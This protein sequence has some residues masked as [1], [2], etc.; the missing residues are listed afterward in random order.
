[1]STA[2]RRP[3]R[4]RPELVTLGASAELSDATTALLGELGAALLVVPG[5]GRGARAHGGVDAARRAHARATSRPR[6]SSP[7]PPRRC[8]WASTTST[9]ACSSVA[10]P[11]PRT[12]PS[13][14]PPN[15]WPSSA[16]SRPASSRRADS[17]CPTRKRLA[18]SS[19]IALE[20]LPRLFHRADEAGL[21]VRDGAFWLESDLGARVDAAERGRPL[22]PPRPVLARPDS[23]P[24]ARARRASQRDAHR[25]RP[26][27]RRALVLPGRRPVDRRGAR[28]AG[29]RRRGARPRGGGRADRGGPPRARRRHRPCG[30]H[31]RDPLPHEVDKVYLQHDLSIVAPGPLEPALDARLRGDGRR[32]GS[33]PRLELPGHR[34][35]RDPRPRRRG[36]RPRRSASS[37]T[38]SRSPASRSRSSTCWR[39][40]AARFGSVRV[41]RRRRGRCARCARAMRSDDAQLVRTA[42]R[43]PGARAARAAA[44][45]ATHR[46]RQP[47]HRRRAV[48]DPRRRALSRSPPRT[49]TA[50][51]SGCR[52]RRLAPAPRAAAQRATRSPPSSTRRASRRAS[53]GRPSRPGWRGSSSS[54]VQGEGD[55]HR[56]GAHARRPDRRLPAR[57]GERRRRPPARAR[58]PGRHRAHAA[59]VRD[60][61][62]HARALTSEPGRIRT[63]IT[64]VGWIERYVDGPLI[65]QS[66]R[67]VLLEVAHPDA[68][69][70]RHELAVFAELERAPEHI[71]TYRITR[72]GLWNARAAGHTAEEMLATLERYAKFPVPQT[73]SI[74][75][76]RDRRPLR[77]ARDRRAT[78][79]GAL[80]AALRPTDAAVLAEITRARRIAPAARRAP[81]RRPSGRLQPWA[82]GAA[83]AGAAEARL[84]RRGPRRLHPGH[85]ARDRPRSRTA[86]HCAT[87]SSR[88]STTSS[89]AAPASSCCPAARARRSSAPARW[90]RPKTT[91]LILVTNTVS[92]RQ[93]RAELLQA[94]D[95]HRGR[96]RRVLRAGAR[97]SSRS[98]SRRTRSSRRSGRAST[99]TSRCSTRSTGASSST[100]RCT[101]C[102][103]RCSS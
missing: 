23:R 33:R 34:G 11:R 85:P 64:R 21:V 41:A 44:G 65:V 30:A 18:E 71:H 52:R 35:I 49:A 47:V 4:C 40:T 24:A 58:P 39:E 25:D 68:E 78:A 67:T 27:R 22:A 66:D 50:R 98:R 14:R 62:G 83:Q 89:T 46:L 2:T 6:P 74:D 17:H 26:A 100:T 13:P 80:R 86:G 77:A 57:A 7:R 28:P 92:A 29:R 59:A 84:A 75:I 76:E 88:P 93:W 12:P 73:V 95:A 48:L 32:G 81:R 70:A 60:R 56:H 37:S 63:P 20:E 61:R 3:T 16:A 51:S 69:D 31:A 8:S 55:G 79:D 19:G 97:R 10:P 94:H 91:T 43:R 38:G 82:R 53:R 1:M 36:D 101:C 99:P 103:P 15:C 87:T 54:A 45:R 102:P 5:D 96:D 42:R 90:R 72:L 9:A